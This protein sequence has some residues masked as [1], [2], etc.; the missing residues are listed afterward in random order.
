[1]SKTYVT[2]TELEFDSVFPANK[3]WR[4]EESGG[5]KEIVYLKNLRNNPDIC[6]KVYSSI[7]KDNGIGRGC[8]KDAI[9]VCA[10]NTRLNRGLIKSSRVYRV[11]GWQDRVR[12]RVLEVWNTAKTRANFS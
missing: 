7:K 4:K 9:R 1:M 5:T 8:G 12:A 2:V 3:N 6:V 10:V 11:A